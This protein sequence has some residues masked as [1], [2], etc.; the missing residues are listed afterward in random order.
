ML[1]K[2]KTLTRES[3]AVTQCHAWRAGNVAAAPDAIL[4][5]KFRATDAWRGMGN[6]PVKRM[7][8]SSFLAIAVMMVPL[9]AMAQ[10]LRDA[11]REALLERLEKIREAND[12]KVDE[13][14]RVA[15]SAFRSAMGSD[16]AALDLYLKCVEK[17]QFQDEQKK[18]Q[19]FRDW[20]RKEED[21]LKKPEF[22]RALRYQLRWLVITLQAA[23]SKKDGA[24]EKIMQEVRD[25][26]DTAV[27]DLGN[28][29]D[30][31]K[32]VRQGA[33]GSVFAKAY[34]LGNVKT[35]GM[36]AH[37]LDL[38]G[39]YTQML[40]PAARKAGPEAVRSTWTKRIYQ[41][42]AVLEKSS[43]ARA[44]INPFG[45][46][47]G[48]Q[49]AQSPE[50]Q[51]FREE[52]VFDLNWSMEEDVFKC[53]DQ[54]GAAVNMLALIEKHPGHPHVADWAKRL[55]GLLDSTKAKAEAGGEPAQP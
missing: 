22:K 33:M 31:A 44:S 4:S 51:K 36:P 47:I 40:L 10:A 9:S 52:G 39:L 7:L 1:H 29:G 3:G 5:G 16:D 23:S 18:G 17:V 26:V 27:N 46:P 8:R 20:K 11:D 53:G 45:T 14:Y 21:H 48:N 50:V 34:E 25:T 38:N 15:V 55:Q 43:G 54:R 35:E 32:V 42:L 12:Q 28:L 49:D 19:D 37:P 24:Q 30:E 2:T 13:R 41:E 6:V